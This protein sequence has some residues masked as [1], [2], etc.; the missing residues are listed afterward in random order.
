[1]HIH[2]IAAG[3]GITFVDALKILWNFTND[4]PMNFDKQKKR[5]KET[6]VLFL[7]KL[8][9][10]LDDYESATDKFGLIIDYL[11]RYYTSK[12]LQLA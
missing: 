7:E 3:V 4:R 2:T 6:F 10:E 5:Y 8:T 1:M 11:Q 9:G 12:R